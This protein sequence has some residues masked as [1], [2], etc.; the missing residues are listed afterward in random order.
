VIA[1]ARVELLQDLRYGA[2]CVSSGMTIGGVGG[3]TRRMLYSTG[4]TTRVKHVATSS[5]RSPR[6]RAGVL[7]ATFAQ[8]ERHRQHPDDHRER[9]HADGPQPHGAGL[10][11]CLE[12]RAS[13]PPLLI[14][15]VMSRTLFAVA[16]PRAMMLPISDGTLNVV[17]VVNSIHTIPQSAPGSAITITSGSSQDWS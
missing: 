11:G 7:L 9:R 6:G 12:G 16:T 8:A 14:A 4:T 5:L 3:A 15:K 10:E 1:L 17:W 2:Q 13:S